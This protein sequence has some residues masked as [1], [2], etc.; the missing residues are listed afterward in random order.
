ME[1]KALVQ[2]VWDETQAAYKL[3]GIGNYVTLPLPVGPISEYTGPES[4]KNLALR[5]ASAPFSPNAYQIDEKERA[6]QLFKVP[7]KKVWLPE[8]HLHSKHTIFYQVFGTI[9]SFPQ[10]PEVN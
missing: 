4:I 5:Y 2:L 8:G 7:E 10:T 1:N 9:T 3:R 6:F